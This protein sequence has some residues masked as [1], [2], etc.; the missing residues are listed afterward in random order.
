MIFTRSCLLVPP[1]TMESSNQTNKM[2]QTVTHL[3]LMC[4]A[5]VSITVMLGI[6]VNRLIRLYTSRQFT[7]NPIEYRT[8]G[9]RYVVYTPMT[10][11]GEYLLLTGGITALISVLVGIQV[12]TFHVVNDLLTSPDQRELDGSHMAV[13]CITA[14]SLMFISFA[15]FEQSRSQEDCRED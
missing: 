7:N 6:L 11:F 9:R 8:H 4:S 12:L 5:F 2:L 1:P 14:L 10:D 13:T 3:T 15:T